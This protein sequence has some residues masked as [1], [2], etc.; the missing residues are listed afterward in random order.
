MEQYIITYIKYDYSEPSKEVIC[1]DLKEV[2]KSM[3][4]NLINKFIVVKMVI[5]H[6]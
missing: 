5:E 2:Q 6:Y 1:K 3:S 4:E